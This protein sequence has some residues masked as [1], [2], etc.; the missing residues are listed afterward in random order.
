[1]KKIVL[2]TLIAAAT[3]MAAANYNKCATCHGAKAEKKL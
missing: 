2:G 3:M 1:M